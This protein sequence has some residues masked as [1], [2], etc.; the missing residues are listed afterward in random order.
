[1]LGVENVETENGCSRQV[2]SAADAPEGLDWRAVWQ[3]TSMSLGI[4]LFAIPYC[5]LL[6]G[7]VQAAFLVVVMGLLANT[8]LQRLLDISLAH[9]TASYEAL[10]ELAFGRAGKVAM[11]VITMITT[12]IATLS[13]LSASKGLLVSVAIAFLVDVDVNVNHDAAGNPIQVEVLGR[14]QSVVVLFFLVCM[15]SPMLLSRSMGD[16]AWISAGGVFSISLS[17]LFFVGSCLAVLAGGCKKEPCHPAPPALA[18]SA[19]EILQYMATL[20]FSFSMVF[21]LFPV[22]ADRAAQRSLAGAVKI[23]RPAVRMSISF[24]VSIYLLVG[25]M[26]V[27]TFGTDT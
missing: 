23:L 19:A 21:A 4:G 6:L 14:T 1:M 18:G 26:G 2:L 3:L 13:Y 22:L 7:Y 11:T 5:F 27:L 25:F 16:S 20:A 10:A 17:A 8:A 9:D 24:S 15:V 12:T